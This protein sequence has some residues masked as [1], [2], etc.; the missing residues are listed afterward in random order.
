MAEFLDCWL[1]EANLRWIVKLLVLGR[2]V[3]EEARW[4]KFAD[5]RLP[6]SF[7]D[8]ICDFLKEVWFSWEEAEELVT[9]L[10]MKLDLLL[11]DC[12]DDDSGPM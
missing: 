7:M 11:V 2:F 8:F 4:L 12:D 5:F 10:E 1:V 6:H 3:D 9:E